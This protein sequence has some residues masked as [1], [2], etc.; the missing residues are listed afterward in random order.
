MNTYESLK[1]EVYLVAHAVEQN[2][3]D[4]FTDLKLAE[5]HR[6][7]WI[8]QD[9][10]VKYDSSVNP[11]KLENHGSRPEVLEAMETGYGEDTRYSKTLAEKN[12]LQCC[13]ADGRHDYESFASA[14]FYLYLGAQHA[15]A[16]F[17]CA[18]AGGDFVIVIS[19]TDCQKK[20]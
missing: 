13:Q 8:G 3:G 17:N 14:V 6:I 12:H 18:G 19:G 7:T 20:S 1:N 4:Y 5:N 15:A 9:G 16:D 2:G 10:T 11:D